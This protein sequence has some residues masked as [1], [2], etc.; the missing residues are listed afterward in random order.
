MFLNVFSNFWNNG[1]LPESHGANSEAVYI[2]C[3]SLASVDQRN[4][5]AFWLFWHW[6]SCSW[7]LFAVRELD[8]R[9][10]VRSSEDVTWR[11]S[12]WVFA[13][14]WTLEYG[15]RMSLGS[16]CFLGFNQ[17]QAQ[18]IAWFNHSRW[19]W[20]INPSKTKDKKNTQGRER[21]W[22]KENGKI[23]FQALHCSEGANPASFPTPALRHW[24]EDD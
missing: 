22:G 19:C 6:E 17:F 7:F 15:M 23:Y 3:S 12:S 24:K 13:V 4:L 1:M 10:S 14:P 16:V 9:Y 20:P 11:F 18:G 2:S 8:F 21:D 5:F